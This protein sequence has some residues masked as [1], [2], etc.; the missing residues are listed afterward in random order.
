VIE[1]DGRMTFRHEYGNEEIK[2][3]ETDQID[4][5]KASIKDAAKEI[6]TGDPW[7][8]SD[9]FIPAIS[10]PPETASMN[11]PLKPTETERYQLSTVNA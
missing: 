4:A 11:Y 5:I 10:S 2:Y 6:F 3:I 1:A 7:S 8:M 9:I